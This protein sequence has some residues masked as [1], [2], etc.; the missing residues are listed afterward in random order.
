MRDTCCFKQQGRGGHF[1]CTRREVSFK[2]T[3]FW[4]AFELPYVP[5]RNGS[6]PGFPSLP[7]VSVSAQI[8]RGLSGC[9]RSSTGNCR[10]TGRRGWRWE[11]WTDLHLPQR[12]AKLPPYRKLPLGAVHVPCSCLNF[13]KNNCAWPHLCRTVHTDGGYKTP[14]MSCRHLKHLPTSS[15][16]LRVR[17]SAERKAQGHSLCLCLISALI[18]LRPMLLQLIYFPLKHMFRGTS[19]AG[20]PNLR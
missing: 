6:A 12:E 9:P 8:V 14:L 19:K 11:V 17:G 13:F 4:K 10:S 16:T 18:G 7:P 1:K 5:Q 3:V 20:L 2:K 15:F